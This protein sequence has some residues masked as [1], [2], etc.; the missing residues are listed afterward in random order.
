MQAERRFR[1][2]WRTVAR[3][4]GKTLIGAGVI[5]LLF[6]AYQ[7]WGTGIAEARS[8]N[9]LKKHFRAEVATVPTTAPSPAGGP[10]TTVAALPPPPTGEAIAIL[11]IPKIGVN[12]AVV[13]GVG[14]PDL[15]KGPGHY[16]DTPLPGQ[17]GN[18]AIAGHRTTYGAPFFNLDQLAKGDAIQITTRTGATLNYE[19][20]E[21][22]V[23]KPSD[24]SVVNPTTD[25][26]LTL[27]TCNPRYSASQRLVVIAAL[28][29]QVTEAATPKPAEGTASG[30]GTT[31]AAP[32]KPATAQFG[33]G[34][35]RSA[36]VPSLLWGLATLWV[37][38]AMWMIGRH[39]KRLVRWGIY[40]ACSPALV[41]VMFI[42]FQQVNKLLPANI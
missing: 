35:Q 1:L 20:S 42:W 28:K 12:K 33:L 3:G 36:R 30:S 17:P 29:G 15:K 31:P 38:L 7:L 41:V 9:S 23:V 11:H 10:P 39:R 34:G 32:N 14:V 40:V 26:R 18:V 19:V 25:N 22:K 2:D 24:V 6:V 13:E 21:T 27:T 5:V 16:P 37:G 4:I 8:Q